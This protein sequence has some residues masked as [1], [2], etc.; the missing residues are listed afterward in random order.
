MNIFLIFSL[1]MCMSICSHVVRTLSIMSVMAISPACSFPR[2]LVLIVE[3]NVFAFRLSSSS[4]ISS[5]SVSSE[6]SSCSWFV[7]I[8]SSSWSMY[9]SLSRLSTPDRAVSGLDCSS[10]SVIFW[11]DSFSFSGVVLLE[12][13]FEVVDEDLAEP[14]PL[15]WNDL[16]EVISSSREMGPSS[17]SS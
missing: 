17:S 13:R 15:C 5:S 1:V 2:S 10:E 4:S 9:S 3:M 14:V 6:L 8:S 11:S 7:F 16:T 12:L